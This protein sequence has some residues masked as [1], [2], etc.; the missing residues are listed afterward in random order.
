[1]MRSNLRIHGVPAPRDGETNEEVLSMVK[2]IGE[3]LG[4]KIEPNDI[5]RAHRVGKINTEKRKDGTLTGKKIQS[6][7]VRFRSWEKRCE[8][9]RARPKR[10]EEKVKRNNRGKKDKPT[11]TYQSVSLDL[12]KASRDLL[13]TANSKINA[14]FPNQDDG[15]CYAFADINCNLRLKLP[16]TEKKFVNFSTEH[17]LDKVLADL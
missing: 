2:S 10:G 3:D 13:S 5:Y 6:V 7:I 11:P 15:H 1:M 12:S 9:Y 14:K 17:E 16:G 4:V 8:L